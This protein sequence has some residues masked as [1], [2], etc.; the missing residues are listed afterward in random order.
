VNLLGLLVSRGHTHLRS[1]VRSVALSDA[2]IDE[3]PVGRIAFPDRQGT[4]KGIPIILRLHLYAS[5]SLLLFFYDCS[6]FRN[7]KFKQ[8]IREILIIRELLS[9]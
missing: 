9:D 7:L 2:A 4:A 5:T 8:I 3:K 6:S 1:K